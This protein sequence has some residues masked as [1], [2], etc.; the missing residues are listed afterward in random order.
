MRFYTPNALL[1]M[2][3]KRSL[4]GA[5]VAAR[6]LAQRT[7]LLPVRRSNEVSSAWL[8]PGWR[9][10]A[11]SDRFLVLRLAARDERHTVVHEVVANEASHHL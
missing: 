7:T 8:T 3:C 4:V 10:A 9:T 1:T 11:A 5:Q 6:H 2:V